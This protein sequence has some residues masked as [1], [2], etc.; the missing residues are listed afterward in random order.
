MKFLAFLARRL[1]LR[2]ARWIGRGLGRLIFDLIKI[3]KQVTIDNLSRAFPEK[4]PAEIY[5][6]ARA[7]Y[8]HFGMMMME[9]V[10]LW[11][12]QPADIK[13]LIRLDDP[14]ALDRALQEGR[15]AILLT[16]HFG[17]WEYLGA[18]VA[19]SGYPTTYMFQ[20]QAN[21]Y[22]DHFIREY[23]QRMGMQVIPRGMALREYLRALRAGRFVAA[24]ADQDAGR[25]GIFV[26]FLGQLSSTATGPARFA[27]KTGAPILFAISYRDENDDL[28]ACFEYLDIEYDTDNQEKAIR[29][30][31]ESYTQKLESW[32]RKYPNQWFWMHKRW[33]TKP[34]AREIMSQPQ[35]EIPEKS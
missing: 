33:K 32:I 26:K 1:S 15:G 6:I 31:V 24:V 10:K 5:Q 30:I 7:T 20:E 35:L 25:N 11:S 13:Q 28:R 18:W 3:R 2:R 12:L 19:T 34:T 21:P 9:T 22:V 29:Q 4:S 27:F 8:E 16:G 23:R 17:N 14:S